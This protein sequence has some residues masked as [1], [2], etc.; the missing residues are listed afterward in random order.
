[1]PNGEKRKNERGP[2]KNIEE[3][4]VNIRKLA[5]TFSPPGLV[6]PQ[7]RNEHPIA[8]FGWSN[9]GLTHYQKAGTEFRTDS[10]DPGN[11][12]DPDPSG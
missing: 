12:A 5:D 11:N 4:K 8:N 6:P 10:L 3:Y 2:I 1:V 9:F 7:R